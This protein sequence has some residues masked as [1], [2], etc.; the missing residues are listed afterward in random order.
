MTKE[1]G[2]YKISLRISIIHRPEQNRKLL[3]KNKHR[4]K[5]GFLRIF[6]NGANIFLSLFV[7]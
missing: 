2:L 5:S 6:K 1:N 4:F 3:G 7:Q